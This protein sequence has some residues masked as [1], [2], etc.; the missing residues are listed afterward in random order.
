M[1]KRVR[2]SSP[3][4]PNATSGVR[5]RPMMAPG[6]VRPGNPTMGSSMGPKNG[7]KS[8][9]S[10]GGVKSAS[11][12]EDNNRE[13]MRVIATEIEKPTP[14]LVCFLPSDTR[15]IIN[16]LNVLQGNNYTKRTHV[17][18]C[19]Q[20][21]TRSSNTNLVALLSGILDSYK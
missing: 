16:N 11:P 13:I 2:K 21:A 19:I 10:M 4:I 18:D 8:A 6:A 1:V 9:P 3:S 15:K 20:R 5:P 12:A 17:Q 7:P 14:V